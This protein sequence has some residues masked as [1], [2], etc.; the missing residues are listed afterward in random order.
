MKSDDEITLS[1][2]STQSDETFLFQQ[3]QQLKDREEDLKELAD[4]ARR[5][6]A[7]GRLIGEA[8]GYASYEMHFEGVP[9]GVVRPFADDGINFLCLPCLGKFL[10][11]KGLSEKEVDDYIKQLS[12]RYIRGEIVEEQ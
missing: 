11:A 4:G 1:V 10:M 6:R 12:P 8:D 2:T 9:T 5:C 7:C 3:W